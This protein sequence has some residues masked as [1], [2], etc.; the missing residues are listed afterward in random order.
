MYKHV[1]KSHEYTYRWENPK[2]IHKDGRIPSLNIQGYINKMREKP[3]DINTED[4]RIP[5]VYKQNE[6]EKIL[7]INT[8]EGKSLGYNEHKRNYHEYK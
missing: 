5:R 1:E 8:E 6:R 2:N 7:D 4:G 3:L